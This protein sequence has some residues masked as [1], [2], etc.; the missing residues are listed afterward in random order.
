[1]RRGLPLLILLVLFALA[2]CAASAQEEEKPNIVFVLTD[3]SRKDDLAYMPKTRAL[4]GDEGTTFDNA[5][6]SDP[7]CCPSRA[8]ILRSQYAH[9]HKVK[10]NKY[11]SGGYEKFQELKREKSTLATWLEA[12]GYENALIGKYMNGYKDKNVDLS[13]TP[14]GWAQWE[15][16]FAG[17]QYYDYTINTNGRKESYGSDP[18]HYQTDVL[19][20]RA[21]EWTTARAGGAPFFLYL[22]PSAPHEP[23]DPA[24]R[25]EGVVDSVPRP[26]SFAEEDVSDKP[27]WIRK[28][29]ALSEAEK[30]ELDEER[31]KRTE[32]LLS[33]DDLVEHLVT[34]LE[35]SGELDNTYV[36][37][38]SDNG[39]H[40]G[41]HNLRP[42]KVTPYEEDIRVPLLVRGP[43]VPAGAVREEIV[44]NND[45]GPTIADLGGA[46]T[47]HFVDGRSFTP[48][49]YGESPASWREGFL[50]E[51]KQYK[52]G[53]AY[54][55]L[56]PTYKALRTADGK[57]YVEYETGDKELY[58]LASD[59]NEMENIYPMA[60]PTV[61]TPL[62]TRLETLKTC[63]GETCRAAEDLP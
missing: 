17:D 30:Q 44:L 21:S 51:H 31:R 62:K 9:N 4:L 13:V 27:A 33:L 49:L 60:D 41:E 48:L 61:T 39:W 52:S 1:M 3:D 22:T 19:A 35:A 42:G 28:Q 11:P 38:T 23:F 2:G 56:V 18:Q 8:T 59:P 55:S 26:V 46:T 47:P 63:A 24:P 25:H 14:P 45:F 53:N 15:A 16:L 40:M 29:A 58:D 20:G 54:T 43:G 5:F 50:V 37:F 7:L 34:S 10:T 32:L 12:A 6:V 57:K 36:F